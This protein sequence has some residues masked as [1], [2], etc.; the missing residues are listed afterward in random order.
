MTKKTAIKIFI[1]DWGTFPNET[2]VCIGGS[3]EYMIRW[4]ISKKL[5]ADFMIPHKEKIEKTILNK[6]R[7]LAI[8]TTSGQSILWLRQYK[9]DNKS[10]E[11]I[12]VLLH[13][14]HHLIDSVSFQ[15][16][17]DDECEA[18]AYQLEYLFRNIRHKINGVT[19]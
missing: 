16:G 8:T 15:K 3:Y 5:D 17:F 10:W 12:E 14:I 11:D 19:P 9:K 7:G 4:L 13:E 2:L 18:K 6:D 1:Q